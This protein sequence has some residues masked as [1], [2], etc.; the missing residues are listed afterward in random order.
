[1][2][3]I[4]ILCILLRITWTT[5]CGCIFDFW[6]FTVVYSSLG[7]PWIVRVGPKS[8]GHK[9]Y[10][11]H[12]DF[13]TPCCLD[14]LS[15]TTCQGQ[16]DPAMYKSQSHHILFWPVSILLLDG[17]RRLLAL[18]IP[19]IWISPSSFSQMSLENVMVP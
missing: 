9:I 2:D 11:L 6:S 7:D 8:L 5:P 16:Y 18:K 10:Y 13:I 1:V 3:L 4:S 12:S 19:C 15:N 17:G 14:L